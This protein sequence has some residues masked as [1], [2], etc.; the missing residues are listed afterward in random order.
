[1]WFTL[2]GSTSAQAN[3]RGHVHPCKTQPRCLSPLSLISLRFP[4][5]LPP[6]PPPS[7]P[8]TTH[9]RQP[10][11]FSPEKQMCLRGDAKNRTPP[12]SLA[13]SFPGS[14]ARWSPYANQEPKRNKKEHITV[15]TLTCAGKWVQQARACISQ[16][17]I[18]RCFAEPCLALLPI[19]TLLHVLSLSSVSLECWPHSALSRLPRSHARTSILL[20]HLLSLCRL[21]SHPSTREETLHGATRLRIGV[22]KG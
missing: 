17:R 16:G 3:T 14:H 15:S 18:A 7:T 9:P 2:A 10:S 1:M 21:T 11:P 12:S 20:A 5:L 22:Q 6:H 13:L 8:P 19:N 4:L